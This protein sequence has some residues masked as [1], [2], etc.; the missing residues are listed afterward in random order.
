MRARTAILIGLA[1]LIVLPSAEMLYHFSKLP[2]QPKHPAIARVVV[3]SP[4]DGRYDTE[5]DYI[6]VR[7]ASGTGQFSMRHSEITC[8]VGDEVPVDQQG[9]TLKRAAKTCR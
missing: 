6:V 3:I 5:W 2:V 7:N 9:I 4:H 8:S 1:S